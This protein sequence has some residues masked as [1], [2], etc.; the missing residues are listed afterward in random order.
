MK[1]ELQGEYN[2]GR[3]DMAVTMAAASIESAASAANYLFNAAT[4]KGGLTGGDMLI[5]RQHRARL[6]KA[7]ATL[8]QAIALGQPKLLQAAE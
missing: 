1:D 5:L 3:F 7:A 6:Q 8:D 4:S 2:A